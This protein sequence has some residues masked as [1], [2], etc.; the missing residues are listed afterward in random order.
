MQKSKFLK[1]MGIL[2]I[3]FAS[4]AL[5]TSVLCL[6]GAGAITVLNT[7]YPD[8]MDNVL[9]EFPELYQ[10]SDII[11]PSI[12]AAVYELV[13]L[14]LFGLAGSVCQLIGGISALKNHKRPDRVTACIVL[15]A[16]TIAITV[17]SRIALHAIGFDI[18][19]VIVPLLTIIAAATFKNNAPQNN[20]Q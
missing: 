14:G 6:I 13:I 19:T 16:V 5:L 20:P 4:L 1:V 17:L 3:V 2:M 9:S 18:A 11:I 7:T 10:Y 15:S 12:T 8:L